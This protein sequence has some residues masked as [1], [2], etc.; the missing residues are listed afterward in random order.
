MTSKMGFW[1][2][3]AFAPLVGAALAAPA[4]AITTVD[5]DDLQSSYYGNSA[6]VGLGRWWAKTA[7]VGLTG[8]LTEIDVPLWR[9]SSGLN[10]T[11]TLA[12]TTANGAAPNLLPG[13]TLATTS[14]AASALPVFGSAPAAAGNPDTP[15]QFL[16]PGSGLPVSAGETIGIVLEWPSAASFVLWDYNKGAAYPSYDAYS[17][18]QGASWQLTTANT[19]LRTLVSVADRTPVA[20]PGSIALLGTAL[21]GGWT[22]RRRRYSARIRT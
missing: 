13:A 9:L 7:T 1:R 4:A 10:G 2:A 12:I 19:G 5:V 18:D 11:V 6:G 15:V 14:I 8:S 20:E 3:L 17:D 22:L 21:V 16:L